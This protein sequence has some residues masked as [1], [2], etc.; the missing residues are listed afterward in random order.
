MVKTKTSTFCRNEDNV[1]GL[2]NRHSCPLANSQYATIKERDGI[3]YLF[4]KAPERVPYPSKQWERI[5]LKKNEDQAIEQINE[6][7]RYWDR[8]M[9]ARVKLRYLR[10]RDYLKHMRRL[11]LSR[12]K[13]IET[14]NK[15]SER[16][17]LRREEK[18]L[19]VAKLSRTVENELLERLRAATSSKEIYNIDQ[20]AFEEALENEEL[21]EPEEEEEEVVY[22]SASEV[23]EDEDLEDFGVIQEMEDQPEMVTVRT[24]PPPSSSKRQKVTI[25][26]EKDDG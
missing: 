12:Q 11:A 15:K 22:T 23:E 19:R 21:E 17:E 6:H 24:N 14:I 9:R 1:T 7:L 13:K 10:T 2:C 4:V 8:W 16:R 20:A 5:K 25:V 3:I 18:A 26:Y